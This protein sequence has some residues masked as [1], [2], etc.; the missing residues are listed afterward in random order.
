MEHIIDK[1]ILAQYEEYCELNG[2]KPSEEDSVNQYMTEL[3]YQIET[4]KDLNN[5]NNMESTIREYYNLCG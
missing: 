4:E 2:L 1:V 5:L 3:F